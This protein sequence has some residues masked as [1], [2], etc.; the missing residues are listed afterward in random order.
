[1]WL[2]QDVQEADLV[3]ESL[4]DPESVFSLSEDRKPVPLAA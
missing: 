3:A 1:M 2:R 4:Y